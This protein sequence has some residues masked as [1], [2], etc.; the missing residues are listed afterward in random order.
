MKLLRSAVV[1]IL[2]PVVAAVAQDS[3]SLPKEIESSGGRVKASGRWVRAARANSIA[4]LLARLNS[5][6]I[7]CVKDR[8]VCQEAVALLY[9]GEDVPQMSGSFL[10]ALLTEYKITRWDASGITAAA[11]L[12]VAD[13]EIQIDLKAGTA[14]RRHQETKARG[15]RTANPNMI[16]AWELE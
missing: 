10:T 4:P 14:R 11:A 5:V 15:N 16:V 13:V 6:Q 1:A 8:G 9:T 12:P 3:R 7:V 2:L